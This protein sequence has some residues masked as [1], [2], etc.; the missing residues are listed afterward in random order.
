[1]IVAKNVV[2]L[3]NS[4]DWDAIDPSS[5]LPLVGFRRTTDEFGFLLRHYW[6]PET[7]LI[8]ESTTEQR[9]PR[10]APCVQTGR[11]AKRMLR[12]DADSCTWR[13]KTSPW[14]LRNDLVR[15]SPDSAERICT[16]DRFHQTFVGRT[17][18]SETVLDGRTQAFLRQP[19]LAPLLPIPLGFCWHVPSKNGYM[20]FRLES[21]TLLGEMPVLYIRRKGRFFLDA[22]FQNGITHR[23]R[24]EIER[25]G[26]TAYA[27]QR[28]VVLEDRTRDVIIQTEPGSRLAGIEMR[29]TL[30]LVESVMPNSIL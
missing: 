12:C 29:N 6:L 16:Y 11:I 21:H 4:L 7:E 19:I 23:E 9:T 17:S 22:S 24:F 15:F 30:K 25:E 28:C 26:I 14:E 1:M 13:E 18:P 10:L 20:E 8:Y 5:L 3:Q 2:A 27:S